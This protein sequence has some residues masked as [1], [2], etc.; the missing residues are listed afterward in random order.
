ME[1]LLDPNAPKQAPQQ[2]AQPQAAPAG[3]APAAFGQDIIDSDQNSF[4][5]D[6]ME[7]SLSR[8]VLVD[9]WA[10]WCGPCKSLTPTLEKV[11]GQMG[12]TVR[13]VKIDVDQNQELAMQLRIQSV[14]TV[15]AFAGG[16]PVDA[17]M[18]ALPESQVKAFIEKHLG[19]AKPPLEQ[20]LDEG[21]ACLEEGDAQTASQVF[22]EILAQDPK[23]AGAL[24]GL[25]RCFTAVGEIDQGREL[26]EGLPADIKA[27]KDL[28]A[29]IAAM[30]L[31]ELGNAGAGNAFELAEAVALDPKDHQ[32]RFDLAGA[33]I[34]QGRTEEALDHLLEIIR[35]KRDW[36]E[37]AARKQMVKVFEALGPTHET[38]INYRRKLSSV[39]FS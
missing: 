22:N 26:A 18:G 36:N 25:I 34:G 11:V 7:E 20:A 37:E 30:D 24:A 8:L 31:A 32:S 2:A 23:H 28:A 21:M 16:Q 6:V 5:R 19:E 38:V 39:L 33:L 3:A 9:F 29:A 12:G 27:H 4:A 1:F 13:L 35:I 14:P 10:T 17:F 15:Y